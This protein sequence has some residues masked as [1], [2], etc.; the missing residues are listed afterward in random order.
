MLD[1]S[2]VCQLLHQSE[3]EVRR[4]REQ[5]H[6]VSLTIGRHRMY[7]LSEVRDFIGKMHRRGKLEALSIEILN[8]AK[9]DG[10]LRY[11]RLRIMLNI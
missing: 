7:L 4:Y 3:R 11:R 6:L 8:L 9:N 1:F 5:E 10:S 2:E